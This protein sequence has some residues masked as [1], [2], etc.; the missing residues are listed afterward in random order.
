MLRSRSARCGSR[1]KLDEPAAAP[2][3]P[4]GPAPLRLHR[5]EALAAPHRADDP[6]GLGA[7]RDG[8]ARAVRRV[9]LPA[10][11][12]PS[13][14]RALAAGLLAVG[15]G[16]IV[17]N[18]ADADESAAIGAALL[19]A[20]ALG[21]ALRETRRLAGALEVAWVLVLML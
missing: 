1:R 17:A 6:R 3:I 10:V 16:I 7:R 14:T 13:P 20:G 4:H 9:P 15:A 18:R 5:A 19:L 2:P 21:L 12:P 8:R 11:K